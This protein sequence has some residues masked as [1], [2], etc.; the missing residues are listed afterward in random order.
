[1]TTDTLEKSAAAEIR[2]LLDRWVEAVRAND[3]DRIM[4]TYTPDVLAYDAIGSLRFEGA[5]AYGRH[6]K[7]CLEMC[8]GP[9]RFEMHDVH[10]AADGD[11][12]FAHGLIHC[13]ATNDKGEE[14]AAWMRATQCFRRVDGEW[15]IA[16]EH[17]SAPFDMES[18]KALCDLE[19]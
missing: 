8:P 6:W 11:V 19:P 14:E 10:V 7:A 2:R 3:V 1:M 12:G 17:H 15:R 5:E 13:G 9:M 4:S 16:H 18:G